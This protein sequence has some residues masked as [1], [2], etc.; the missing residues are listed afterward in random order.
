[1]PRA[2]TRCPNVGKQTVTASIPERAGIIF[3]VRRRGLSTWVCETKTK[4]GQQRLHAGLTAMRTRCLLNSGKKDW[5]GAP[6][7]SPSHHEILTAHASPTICQIFCYSRWRG[8]YRVRARQL[9]SIAL[10]NRG[11]GSPV[12]R[13][14]AS[15]FSG[16]IS[17][18]AAPGAWVTD[19]LL[20]WNTCRGIPAIVTIHGI[21]LLYSIDFIFYFITI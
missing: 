21:V 1:M 13:L 20:H 18:S 7:L 10:P 3:C 2:Q 11:P 15:V 19:T 9:P 6:S 4:L 8:P 12:L 14:R 16:A 17:E 5:A